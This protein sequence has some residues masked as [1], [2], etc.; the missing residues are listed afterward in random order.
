MVIDF[1]C[2]FAKSNS[3]RTRLLYENFS[4]CIQF[5]ATI[6][7]VVK[8][9]ASHVLK[10]KLNNKQQERSMEELCWIVAELLDIELLIIILL[11]LLCCYIIIIMII[12]IKGGTKIDNIIEAFG[13]HHHLI[14]IHHTCYHQKIKQNKFQNNI[15]YIIY[16]II[17]L[18][19]SKI[20]NNKQRIS[21]IYLIF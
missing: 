15:L 12:I 4:A 11:L 6:F 16:M 10:S 17:L 14:I 7:V 18:L 3:S 8:D 20:I 19:Y 2:S 1:F 13:S 21:D 5:A 9:Y